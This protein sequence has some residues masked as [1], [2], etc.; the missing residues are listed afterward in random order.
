[1]NVML[2]KPKAIAAFSLIELMVV[3]AIVALLSAVAIPSYKDY[4][5]RAKMAE[6]NSLIA[7]QQTLWSDQDAQGAFDIAAAASPSAYID[8]VAMDNT[9]ITV[10]SVDYDGQINVVL[11]DPSGID[12]LL[13]GL[14]VNY[15]AT[16]N[17]AAG[18][19]S[20]TCFYGDAGQ[21]QSTAIEV[22]L[23]ECTDNP[24]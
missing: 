3:I 16:L 11:A 6:V 18:I 14:P 21:A 15:Y 23:P 7:H 17:E 20:W 5:N 19:V 13:D 24:T 4:I 10:N 8:T 2:T 22:Y 9:A 1:M 12:D